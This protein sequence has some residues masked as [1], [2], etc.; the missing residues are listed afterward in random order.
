MQEEAR[1]SAIG[2]VFVDGSDFVRNIWYNYLLTHV[3]VLG[4]FCLLIIMMSKITSTKCFV[5]LIYDLYNDPQLLE[6]L[7]PSRFY[8]FFA[9][10]GFGTNVG[11]AKP[12]DSGS[13]MPCQ[14]TYVYYMRLLVIVLWH[15]YIPGFILSY[16]SLFKLLAFKR[17]NFCFLKQKTNDRIN[18][19][20]SR[21]ELFL[22][23]LVE[24]NVPTI[25]F[26]NFITT[27]LQIKSQQETHEENNDDEFYVY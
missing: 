12:T 26:I 18:N 13:V 6:F 4:V 25:I 5:T 16:Y 7:L 14:W 21:Y 23:K 17:T 9:E 2:Q 15:V 1:L 8:C 3:S 11:F 24:D 27:L 10:Q 22:L 19:C 20:C